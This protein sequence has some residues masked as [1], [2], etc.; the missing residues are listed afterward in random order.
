MLGCGAIPAVYYYSNMTKSTARRIYE[1]VDTDGYRVLVDRLWPRGVT[2]ERAALD[3]WARVAAPS[4]ELRTWFS[5]DQA[6]FK[7][8]SERYLAELEQN[9]EALKTFNA[10][11]EYSNVTLLYA[12]KDELHNEAVVLADH[13]NKT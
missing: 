3:E 12:A 5:H 4:T 9:P 10:W 7:E 8:F 1:S 2:K 11:R 13:L 6:K